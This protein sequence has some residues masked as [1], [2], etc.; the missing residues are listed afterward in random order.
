[1]TTMM[2]DKMGSDEVLNIGKG[3]VNQTKPGSEVGR[4]RDIPS[5]K[6]TRAER[7]VSGRK[8]E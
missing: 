3:K 6:S 1:M 2:V 8:P 7:R 4:N 5:G